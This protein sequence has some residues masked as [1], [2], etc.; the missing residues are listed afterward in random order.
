MLKERL[1]AALKDNCRAS[2]N[3]TRSLSMIDK[4]D[5]TGNTF[6]FFDDQLD[7]KQIQRIRDLYYKAEAIELTRPATRTMKAGYRLTAKF[8]PPVQEIHE[9][10]FEEI[11]AEI[12]EWEEEFEGT[13]IVPQNWRPSYEE[14]MEW[15]AEDDAYEAEIQK[16]IDDADFLK[17]SLGIRSKSASMI[18]EALHRGPRSRK[19]ILSMS[20]SRSSADRLIK[21]LTEAGVLNSKVDAG[22]KIYTLVK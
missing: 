5:L 15:K 2:A 13:N 22:E 12:A 10:R 21:R 11:D 4:I 19:A 6:S 17:K 18:L 1:A 16:R 14:I 9:S 8:L 3:L 7:D 20:S